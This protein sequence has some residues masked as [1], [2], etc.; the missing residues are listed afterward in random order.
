[1]TEREYIPKDKFVVG[2]YYE[3]GCRNARVARWNGTV[4]IYWREK[5]GCVL[6]EAINCPEDDIGFDLFYATREMADDEVEK[7]IPLEIK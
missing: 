5:F 4:F 2:K 7:E 3:G 1:M 6:A